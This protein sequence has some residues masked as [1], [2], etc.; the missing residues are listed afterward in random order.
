MDTSRKKAITPL[1]NKF[2][3]D[4]KETAK[5]IV[6]SSEGTLGLV[7]FYPLDGES[8]RADVFVLRLTPHNVANYLGLHQY[9][10]E[11]IILTD[12]LD[13][14][15]LD[16]AGGFIMSCPDQ[17]FCR[18]VVRILA[19]IQMGETDAEEVDVVARDVFDAYC[20]EQAAFSE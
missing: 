12:M 18:E 11:K 2:I 7:Y 9:D 14:L 3:Q 6:E 8:P 1:N 20:E 5:K 4:T 15:V 17:T 13:R 16:T 10:A 19:P